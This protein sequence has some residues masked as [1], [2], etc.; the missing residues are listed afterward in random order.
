MSVHEH[1]SGCMMH[2][3]AMTTYHSLYY[4]HL[5]VLNLNYI[6]QIKYENKSTIAQSKVR[7][8]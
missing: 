7:F 2:I 3:G 6:R 5:S 4:E 8:L 1:S